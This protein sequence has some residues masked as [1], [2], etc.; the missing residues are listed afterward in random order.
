MNISN[1]EKDSMIMLTCND[2]QQDK[3]P[4][5]DEVFRALISLIQLGKVTA[6]YDD[7]EGCVKY[8]AVSNGLEID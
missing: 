2:W 6:F 1:A 8:Q 3:D 4:E 7:D 5:K